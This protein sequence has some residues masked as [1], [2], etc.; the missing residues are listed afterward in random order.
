MGMKD[1]GRLG[2]LEK[3]C[4]WIIWKAKND[5]IFNEKDVRLP[6]TPQLVTL[7]TYSW[8]ITNTKECEDE[9]EEPQPRNIISEPSLTFAILDR[10]LLDRP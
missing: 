8:R 4:T 10:C 5:K 6:N 2:P 7:E 9:T 3:N 1:E